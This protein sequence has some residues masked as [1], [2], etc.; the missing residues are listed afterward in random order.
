[1]TRSDCASESCC[2]TLPSSV[3]NA[4]LASTASLASLCASASEC[5]SSVPAF[6][7]SV[8]LNCTSSRAAVMEEVRV[9]AACSSRATRRVSAL[10][11]SAYGRTCSSLPSAASAR[12]MASRNSVRSS[13]MIS[14]CS[15]NWTINR[16]TSSAE[17]STACCTA[18]SN[19]CVEAPCPAPEHSSPIE[20]LTPPVVGG[21]DADSCTM[22]AIGNVDSEGPLGGTD[23]AN[24]S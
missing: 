7:I 18:A 16:R 24:S 15:P 9:C 22:A 2:R 19:S 12:A 1:M 20:V 5:A 4:L 14:D 17:S 10:T 3:R 23:N 8:A 21:A 6:C 13:S 11:L